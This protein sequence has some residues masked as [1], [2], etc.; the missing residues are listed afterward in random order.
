MSKFGAKPTAHLS[1]PLNKPEQWTFRKGA[2]QEVQEII[3]VCSKFFYEAAM[4]AA[5]EFCM[6]VQDV[7]LVASP[8]MK[9]VQNI[10]VK[11]LPA[12]LL[13]R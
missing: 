6:S 9:P 1:T 4:I 8:F 11:K 2:G 3:V 10:L 5:R 13:K 7:E 12:Y